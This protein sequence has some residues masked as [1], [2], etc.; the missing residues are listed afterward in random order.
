MLVLL[1]VGVGRLLY[2]PPIA[3]LASL[4]YLAVIWLLSTG[5][6]AM[7]APEVRG[8]ILNLFWLKAVTKVG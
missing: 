4:T 7:V 2:P 8:A 5:A 6:A 1:I 3:P